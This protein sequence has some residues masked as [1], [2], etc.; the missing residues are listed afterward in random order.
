MNEKKAS[1][2]ENTENVIFNKASDEVSVEINRNLDNIK[3]SLN[4]YNQ[5]FTNFNLDELYLLDINYLNNFAIKV[6]APLFDD[7]MKIINHCIID[8]IYDY[9]KV[10]VK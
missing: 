3:T 4:A 7:L 8:K 9:V 5:V 6:I 1:F 2:I 10:K